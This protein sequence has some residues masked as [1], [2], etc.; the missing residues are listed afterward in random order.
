MDREQRTRH[1]TRVHTDSSAV[2][3]ALLHRFIVAQMSKSAWHFCPIPVDDLVL[4]HL[5]STTDHFPSLHLTI[6]ILSRRMAKHQNQ[7]V[8]QQFATSS[9]GFA[10]FDRDK[11]HHSFRR[12]N[13]INETPKDVW[14]CCVLC[15]HQIER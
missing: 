1:R 15:E 10:H 6:V 9:T 11:D 4:H 8:D 13:Q 5:H 14:S 2:L 7:Q 12:E 3:F